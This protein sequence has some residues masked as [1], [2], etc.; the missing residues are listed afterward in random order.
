MRLDVHLHQ[1]PVLE[2]RLLN[3]NIFLQER[4]LAAERHFVDAHGVQRETQQ[5][6]ELQRHVL[7]G[8]SVVARQCR[9]GVQ[10]VEQ[11]VRLKLD[12]QHFKL[13]KGELGFQL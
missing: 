1:Q 8:K 2:A 13:G 10:G 3:V 9:D 11:E 12:L 4:Q 5:I 6:G 7:G